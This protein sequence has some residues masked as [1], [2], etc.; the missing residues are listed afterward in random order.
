MAD[1]HSFMGWDIVVVDDKE[2]VS[3]CNPFGTG[4]GSRTNSLTQLSKLVGVGSVPCCLVAGIMMELAMLD[5][6]TSGGVKN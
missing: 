2:G 1:F 6:L 5:E 4:G 3:A